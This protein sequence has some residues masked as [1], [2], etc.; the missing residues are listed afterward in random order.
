MIS[1]LTDVHLGE[2]NLDATLVLWIQWLCINIQ[3]L[4]T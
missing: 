2:I 3:H 4:I 1:I